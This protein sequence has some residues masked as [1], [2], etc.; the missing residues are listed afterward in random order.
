MIPAI[1][2]STG[3]PHDR[4]ITFAKAILAVPKSETALTAEDLPQLEAEKQKMEAQLAA[5]RREIAKRKARAPSG[6]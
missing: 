4:F 1:S 5:V 6:S 2:D 3:S